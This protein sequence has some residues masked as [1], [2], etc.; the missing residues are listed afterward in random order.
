MVGVQP[1]A[2]LRRKERQVEQLLLQGNQSQWLEAVETEGLWRDKIAR[3]GHVNKK[4][5]VIG[6]SGVTTLQRPVHHIKLHWE[7]R[8]W[9]TITGK[10]LHH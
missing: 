8:R 1:V 6:T 9:R 10:L 7:R 2:F 4:T 3:N 5:G